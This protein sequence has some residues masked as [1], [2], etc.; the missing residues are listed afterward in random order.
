MK[1][2]PS[3]KVQYTSN[4]MNDREGI[5]LLSGLLRRINFSK[6]NEVPRLVESN[7][8]YMSCKRWRKS[9][10]DSFMG[11]YRILGL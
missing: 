11:I 6:R 9:K 2:I 5:K 3:R 7:Q 8:L 4:R 1:Y 10:F